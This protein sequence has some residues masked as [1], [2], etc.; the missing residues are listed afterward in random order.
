[1]DLMIYHLSLNQKKK[2]NEKAQCY[3]RGGK[4]GHDQWT[5]HNTKLAGYGLRLNGLVS[6]SSWHD[7][8]V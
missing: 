8:S 6:Y 5:Q 1:M 2:K 3:N 4:I 7:W